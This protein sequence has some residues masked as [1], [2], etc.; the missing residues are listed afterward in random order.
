MGVRD[1][2]LFTHDFGATPQTS[3]LVNI[4]AG[5]TVADVAIF[6]L[7]WAGGNSELRMHLSSG[8]TAQAIDYQTAEMSTFKNNVSSFTGPGQGALLSNSESSGVYGHAS[9]WNLN[10]LAPVTVFHHSQSNTDSLD[11]TT[12]FDS[13]ASQ[14]QLLISV[15]HNG[16]IN[17]GTIYVNTYERQNKVR[18]LIPGTTS[19][20][21]I[22]DLNDEDSLIVC[23]ALNVGMSVASKMFAQTSTDNGSTWK[24]D[25]ILSWRSQISDDVGASTI[26]QT[27]IMSVSNQGF[28][29]IIRG[30][31]QATRTTMQQQDMNVVA[32]GAFLSNTSRDVAEVENA[33]KIYP[34]TGTFNGGLIYFVSYL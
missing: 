19:E 28:A 25:Y 29:T 2:Q 30:L 1:G 4:P 32:T 33:F 6:G 9:I 7:G 8:G 13:T 34:Q 14:N 17:A 26:I 3:F 16:S 12:L 20:Q 21:V 22:T 27:G 31:P 24:T 11:A 18:V 15:T 23:S 10:T 5:H